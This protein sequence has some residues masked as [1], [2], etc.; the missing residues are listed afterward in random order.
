M[1]NDEILSFI[2]GR[3]SQLIGRP[4]E[5]GDL[6]NEYNMLGADSMDM[7]VLA[8]ELEKLLKITIMPEVFMQHDSVRGALDSIIK[9]HSATA[10]SA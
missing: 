9:L 8:Y 10:K 5:D 4:V 6:D 7:V 2:L 1:S 3:L